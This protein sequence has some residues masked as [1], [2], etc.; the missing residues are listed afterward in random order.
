MQNKVL[1][2]KIIYKKI[3]KMILKCVNV[4]I[5]KK[6][7]MQNKVLLFK[8][9]Y[10]KIRK[11]ILKYSSLAGYKCYYSKKDPVEAEAEGTLLI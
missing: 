11:M 2:F 3:R 6:K 9:I 4:H 1:L 10:K 8:I 7:L 5:S